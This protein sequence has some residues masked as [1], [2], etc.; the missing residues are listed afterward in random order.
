MS[1]KYNYLF[2]YYDDISNSN[3]EILLNIDDSMK[4][5]IIADLVERNNICGDTW[6]K[7]ANTLPNPI[8]TIMTSYESCCNIINYYDD[9][10][11]REMWF[12][13]GMTFANTDYEKDYLIDI[14]YSS[15]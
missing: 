2:K 6:R 14:M 15:L 12:R 5:N 11:I 13:V 10:N 7:I 4:A 3:K 8:N 1:T 9:N